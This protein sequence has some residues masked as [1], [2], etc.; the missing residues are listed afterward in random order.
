MLFPLC[1]VVLNPLV[2][3]VPLADHAKVLMPGAPVVKSNVGAYPSHTISDDGVDTPI[4]V[5]LTEIADDKLALDVQPSAVGVTVYLMVPTV[6]L[7][8]LLNTSLI[9]APLDIGEVPD[10][11]PLL[12]DSNQV[13]VAPDTDEL[14]ATFDGKPLQIDALGTVNCTSGN[15][16]TVTTIPFEIEVEVQVFPSV[17]VVTE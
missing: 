6:V 9:V 15:G 11:I 1:V 7:V 2:P 5:G 8:V 13:N 16:F 10:T 14:N 4:G 3:A 12:F 17:T